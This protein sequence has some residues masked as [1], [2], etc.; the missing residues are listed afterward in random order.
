MLMFVVMLTTFPTPTNKIHWMFTDI[1]KLYGYITRT[2]RKQK[3][4]SR[5]ETMI[6]ANLVERMQSQLGIASFPDAWKNVIHDSIAILYIQRM[7]EYSRTY[8]LQK[9]RKWTKRLYDWYTEEASQN[10]MPPHFPFNDPPSWWNVKTNPASSES[11][12]S[13]SK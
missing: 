10:T 12:K 6:F 3:T 9:A 1:K 4:L 2:P 13:E 11:S 5:Y 8:K 7:V